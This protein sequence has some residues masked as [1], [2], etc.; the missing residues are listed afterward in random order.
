MDDNLGDLVNLL[1]AAD[2]VTGFNI[3]GFDIPLLEATIK[4]KLNLKKVYDVLE[5]SRIACGWNP[6]NDYFRYPK[7]LKLDDHLEGTFGR[8]SM[9]T[10]N[11]AD[12]PLMWQSG[13]VGTLVSYCLADV[14]REL[15]LFQHILSGEPVKTATH[16]SKKISIEVLS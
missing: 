16:G 15:K 12:A 6:G 7:G 1:E 3:K 2:V 14:K 11:G 9:K 8:D 4:R 10:A 5:W 13:K